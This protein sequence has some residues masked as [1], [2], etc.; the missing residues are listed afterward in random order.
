MTGE[1][2]TKVLKGVPVHTCKC[3]TRVV[4]A[5]LYLAT[6]GTRNT[7]WEVVADREHEHPIPEREIPADQRFV[8]GSAYDPLDDM[9]DDDG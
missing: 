8:P 9:G 6:G 5:G 7:Y 1:E 3:G 4:R 2:I